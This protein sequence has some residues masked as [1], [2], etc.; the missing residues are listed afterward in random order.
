MEKIAAGKQA[1]QFYTIAETEQGVRVFNDGLSGTIKFRDYLQS[2]ADNFYSSSLQDVESLNIYRIETVS[3]RVRR[4]G[5]GF[6][7]LAYLRFFS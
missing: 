6:G 5:A 4:K 3:R 7:I 2:T 1:K